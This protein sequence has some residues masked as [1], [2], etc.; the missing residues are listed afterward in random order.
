MATPARAEAA[1]MRPVVLI[2]SRRVL[3]ELEVSFIISIFLTLMPRCQFK[4]KGK[5]GVL[6]NFRGR[7]SQFAFFDSIG[8]I[9]NQPDHEPNE[10][11]YP[12]HQR[13]PKHQSE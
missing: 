12:G 4:T 8:E 5:L 13:Q 10:Q 11:S 3:R 9:D 7:L 1:A 6:R 2:K